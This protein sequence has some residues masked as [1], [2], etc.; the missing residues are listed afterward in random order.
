MKNLFRV[1]V[2]CTAALLAECTTPA[3]PPELVSVAARWQQVPKD[4]AAPVVLAVPGM[5]QTKVASVAYKPGHAMDVYYPGS[6]AFDG[7]RLPVVVFAMGYSADFTKGWFGA[8][9]KD[10]GQ[11]V[12]WGE[13]VAASGMIGVAYQTDY[14]DDDLDA[15]LDFIRAQGRRLGMDCDRIAVF[16]CSGNAQTGLAA[17]ADKTAEY[18]GAIRCGVV[19]YPIISYFMNKGEEVMPAPF[20]RELR[21]DVPLLIVA[22]GDE[23]PEWKAAVEG[24]L[25]GLEGRG[26]PLQVITYEKGVHGF[27]TD[28]PTDESKQIV[29]KT[30]AF[31]RQHMA[32]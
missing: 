17:L 32:K 15:V 18:R 3:R 6:Y 23:R 20:K 12:S 8:E 29:E 10:L 7:R 25:A 31:F 5:E 4:L 24:F 11:Y 26:L 13:I 27:D 14:P 30:L 16:A 28:Q 2:I 21:K 22:I 9:L 1:T 19:Y